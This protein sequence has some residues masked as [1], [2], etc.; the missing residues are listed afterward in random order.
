MGPSAG[1]SRR[2]CDTLLGHA[3][4]AD[5]FPNPRAPRGALAVASSWLFVSS[6][7]DPY[8][9]LYA[10]RV[11]PSVAGSVV[12]LLG[13]ASPPTCPSLPLYPPTPA[14]VLYLLVFSF[15]V[16]YG[17]VLLLEYRVI[18]AAAAA[19]ASRRLVSLGVRRSWLGRGPSP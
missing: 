13:L 6:Q 18:D 9:A 17:V 19:T 12:S 5:T 10:L 15:A 3:A 14:Q 7:S 4:G 11:F 8:P 2:L 1:A 16:A